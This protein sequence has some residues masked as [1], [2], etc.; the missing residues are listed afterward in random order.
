M[1]SMRTAVSGCAP[2]REHLWS[3]GARL[4]EIRSERRWMP[5]ENRE[6]SVK[7]PYSPPELEEF[8]RAELLTE[9]RDQVLPYGTKPDN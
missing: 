8:G 2:P 7:R 1:D 3:G 9:V 6:E 4:V 5:M